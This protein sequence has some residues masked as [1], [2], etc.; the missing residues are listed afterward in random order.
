MKQEAFKASPNSNTQSPEVSSKASTNSE[1]VNNS[2]TTLTQKLSAALVNVSAKEDL[3][4][5][6]AKVAE[7]AIAGITYNYMLQTYRT[8]LRW[9]L[10]FFFFF[11]LSIT[12]YV[13]V[14][15]LNLRLGKG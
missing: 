14:N 10:R 15:F 4:K 7:E 11:R 5:Q 12:D 9:L 13:L 3:V 2:I 8:C 1:D 6:H